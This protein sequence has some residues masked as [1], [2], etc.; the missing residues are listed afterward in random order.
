MK[1]SSAPVYLDEIIRNPLSF[2]VLG[3]YYKEWPFSIWHRQN[4][5]MSP[6]Y[7]WW[8][9]TQNFK[10][11]VLYLINDQLN[12]LS[13]LTSGN[14]MLINQILAKIFYFPQIPEFWLTFRMRQHATP[15]TQSLKVAGWSQS[16]TFSVRSCHP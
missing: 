8:D 10:I 16:G 6:I 4:L 1:S 7:L 14:K 5:Q 15:L 12:C 3:N 2:H 13:P 11:P 9:P